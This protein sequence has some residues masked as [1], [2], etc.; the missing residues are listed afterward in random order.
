MKVYNA[1]GMSEAELAEVTAR[2]RIDFTSILGTVG[3]HPAEGRRTCG[4]HVCMCVSSHSRPLL[5]SPAFQNLPSPEP[6]FLALLVS[7]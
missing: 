4:R 6:A 1:S 5:K 2:P 7:C 3:T